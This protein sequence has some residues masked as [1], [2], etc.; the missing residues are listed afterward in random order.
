MTNRVKLPDTVNKVFDPH[1]GGSLVE[2]AF[3]NDCLY[4][5][6][7]GGKWQKTKK[8]HLTKARVKVLHDLMNRS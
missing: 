8:V 4:Q 2:W 1:Y 7:C 6:S 3:Y 5:R